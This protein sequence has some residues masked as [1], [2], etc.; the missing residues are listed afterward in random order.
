V[1]HGARCD[2]HE[3]AHQSR[4]ARE[5]LQ[6]RGSSSSRGYTSKWTDIRTKFM[7]SQPTCQRC[8]KAPSVECHHVVP[9]KLGGTH[10]TANL[11]ALCLSCHRLVEQSRHSQGA[12]A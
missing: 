5:D 7:A 2:E 3:A 12:R 9:L 11:A 4:L 8:G 6:L 10:D 1:R